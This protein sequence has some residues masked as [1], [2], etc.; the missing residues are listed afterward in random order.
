[1]GMAYTATMNCAACKFLS[2]LFESYIRKAIMIPYPMLLNQ[3]IKSMRKFQPS[4]FL[5]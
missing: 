5:L 4:S 2:Y 1:M 3:P